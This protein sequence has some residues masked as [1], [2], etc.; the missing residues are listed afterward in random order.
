M[1]ILALAALALVVGILAAFLFLPAGPQE[2]AP[3]QATSAAAPRDGKAAREETPEPPPEEAGGAAPGD[4]A[5]LPDAGNLLDGQEVSPASR[6]VTPQG[7]TRGPEV[8]GPLT[9]IVPPEPPAP[10]EPEAPKEARTEKLFRPVAT[11][12]ST[13][14]ARK[15]E[16]SLAGIDAPAPEASCG[17][18]EWP[19]GQMARAALRRLIRTRAVDCVVPAGERKLPAKTQCRLGE[20]DLGEWLVRRG[21][22]RA[23]A[24]RYRNAEEEAR[25]EKLGIW[26]PTR[27]GPSDAIPETAGPAPIGPVGGTGDPPAEAPPQPETAPAPTSPSLVPGL[28]A[29]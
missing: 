29:E 5:T 16:V 13:L 12:A 1:R 9:R 14:K 20:T 18:E 23:S 15:A 2:S 25:R 22:A 11:S 3:P 10:P 26:S 28:P 27:P 8:T 4:P 24:E 21:W 19:C 6:D 17:E 7:F